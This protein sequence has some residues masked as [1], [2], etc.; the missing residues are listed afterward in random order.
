MVAN[1]TSSVNYVFVESG[2]EY[3]RFVEEGFGT[4]DGTGGT[5]EG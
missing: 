2:G 1:L 3:W 5:G 4:I